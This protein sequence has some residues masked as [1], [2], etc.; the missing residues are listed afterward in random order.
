MELNISN[1]DFYCT[2]RELL[3]LLK[4]ATKIGYVKGMEDAGKAPKYISQN[5][6]YKAFK[7]P[8]VQAWVN[9][10]FI[11]GKPNGN[12]RTSTV[13]YEYAKLLELDASEEIK[14]R[15]PYISS[16]FNNIQ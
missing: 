13:Y 5:R 6:A 2:R 7:K 3:N 1:L 12:G 8:R 15:K 11:L 10:G 9:D 14:I 4:E 16:T